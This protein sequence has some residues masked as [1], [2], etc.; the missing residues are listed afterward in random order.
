L[1]YSHHFRGVG[2]QVWLACT[3]SLPVNVTVGIQTHGLFITSPASD[4][5]C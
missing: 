3:E 1:P 2:I 4:P 5:L